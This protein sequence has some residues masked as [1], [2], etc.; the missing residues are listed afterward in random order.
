MR[1]SGVDGVP[2]KRFLGA[3][4]RMTDGSG[5]VPLSA[6]PEWNDTTTY[7]VMDS[8]MGARIEEYPSFLLFLCR[9]MMVLLRGSDGSSRRELFRS[10]IL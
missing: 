5:F 10:E 4:A 7:A 9:W 1:V 6:F 2:L 3:H 8:A